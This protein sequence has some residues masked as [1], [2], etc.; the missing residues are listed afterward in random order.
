MS[1]M[2]P[3]MSEM[4]PWMSEMRPWMS[5]SAMFDIHEQGFEKWRAFASD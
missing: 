5:V 4:P 1:E 2:L 3:W